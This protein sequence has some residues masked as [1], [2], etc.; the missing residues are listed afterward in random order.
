MKKF[1][2]GMCL[3]LMSLAIEKSSAQQKELKFYGIIKDSITLMPISNAAV[4]D[5]GGK[6]ATYSNDDGMF[7]LLVNIGDTIYCHAP[8]FLDATYIIKSNKYQMDT[9]EIWLKPRIKEDLPGVFV[10]TYI[11]KDYQRDSADRMKEFIQDVGLKIPTFSKSNSGAGLGISLDGLF[12]KKN[13]QKKKAYEDFKENE[14]QR[15]VDFRFKPIFVNHYSGL[16]G[17]KLQDFMN[18]YRPSYEWLRENPDE[19]ALKYY[20]NDKLKIYFQRNK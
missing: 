13:K 5:K 16:K 20:V 3:L 15:Y 2:F 4:H 7:Q 6:R 12:S 18:K 10:S 1:W 9:V 11:Y 17:A 19:E 14:K 8:S